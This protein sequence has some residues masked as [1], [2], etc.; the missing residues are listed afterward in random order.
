MCAGVGGNARGLVWWRR[1]CRP[2][3][4][5]RGRVGV[6]ADRYGAAR[7]PAAAELALCI[8]LFVCLSCRAGRGHGA[9]R[10]SENGSVGAPPHTPACLLLRPAAGLSA[11]VCLSVFLSVCLSVCLSVSLSVCLSVCLSGCPSVCLSVCLSGWQAVRLALCRPG[12]LAL[13]GWR[14]GPAAAGWASRGPPR[15]QPA[16]PPRRARQRALAS[17][18]RKIGET[19]AA[20]PATGR[21]R[22]RPQSSKSHT[23]TNSMKAIRTLPRPC[24]FFVLHQPE[25]AALCFA[26]SRV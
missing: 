20:I 19:P 14:A 11:S 7:A 15:G 26:A 16:Q 9:V 18:T 3:R 1:R 21:Q 8:P 10:A 12:L 13:A 24:V 4:G 22:T 5:G 17:E 6:G 23:H 2:P 25:A